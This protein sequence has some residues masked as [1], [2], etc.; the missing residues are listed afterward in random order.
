MASKIP[1]KDML[2]Q[3]DRGNLDYY[4]TFDADQKKEFSPWMTMRW[5]STVKGDFSEHYLLMVNGIVNHEFS[6]LNKHPELQWKL[7]AVC[8]IGA[9][10]FH[11]WVKPP[12]KKGKN[13]IQ[14]FLSKAYPHAKSDEL[15]LLEKV[16]TKQELI[17]LAQD[18]GYS[19]KE[20]KD[21][22]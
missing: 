2:S 4:S 14:E 3:I 8:G 19:D 21:L 11:Q 1:L 16:N 7:I 9:N 17:Y 5:A 10:Q 18:M 20:I 6:V 15:A 13:K 12:K 22:F